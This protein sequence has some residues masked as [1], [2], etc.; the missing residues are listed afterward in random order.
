[1]DQSDQFLNTL[2]EWMRIFMHNSMHNA[3]LYSKECGWSMSQLGALM[4]IH[5]K[6]TSA[7][8]D[9]GEE[10]GISNPAASQ[11]IDKL[12]Q[13]NLLLRTEDPNDRRVKQIKLTE[14]GLEII[15][16]SLHAR[17]SWLTSLTE[18]LTADQKEQI[19]QALEILINGSKN[20]EHS[21]GI[22]SSNIHA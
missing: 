12:V 8:S 2:R 14:K 13:D 10:M 15:H 7:I 6:G 4:F 1:M 18:E 19:S 16:K 21:K 17:Q 9:I 22:E 3:L 5:R 11:M 20:I